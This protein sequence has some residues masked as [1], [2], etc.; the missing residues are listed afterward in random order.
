MSTYAPDKMVPSSAAATG[1]MK[2]SAMNYSAEPSHPVWLGYV[3]WIFGFT[4]S[5]RF[6]YGRN[7]TGILW[8]LTG[9]LFLV[10]WIIDIVFIPSMAE[11]ASRRYPTGRID[12]SIAWLLHMFLG[13]FGLHRFY[14]GKV[15]TGVIWLLTGGLFTLGY[16]YD[17][18][19]LNDQIDECNRG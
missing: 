17:T 11:S 3:F 19:T 7:L 8:L 14:M 10:G 2:P 1:P 13:I 16:I 9:G 12:Y 5:H 4:G 18:L 6:F 15:V